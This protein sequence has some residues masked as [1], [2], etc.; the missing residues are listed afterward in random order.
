M[1][2]SELFEFDM[3][4]AVRSSLHVDQIPGESAVGQCAD[5]G[6]N[7]IFEGQHQAVL[8]AYGRSPECFLEDADLA[9]FT[10][11]GVGDDQAGGERVHFQS[12]DL[13]PPLFQA[14]S[15]GSGNVLHTIGVLGPD[16][17]VLAEPVDQA[18]CWT[19]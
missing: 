7:D 12:A 19:A 17:E 4:P 2:P 5:L 13:P 3:A 10:A 16:V 15:H 9:L 1:A 14:R 6:P 8:G 11:G 18:V